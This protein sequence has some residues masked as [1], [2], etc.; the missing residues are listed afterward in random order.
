MKHTYP[1]NVAP[2]H[3]FERVVS[4]IETAVHGS[5]HIRVEARKRLRD[6]HTGRLREHDVVVTDTEKQP[7]HER[8]DVGVPIIVLRR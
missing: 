7:R 6:I 3:N 2:G 5:P 8:L 1:A 4:A